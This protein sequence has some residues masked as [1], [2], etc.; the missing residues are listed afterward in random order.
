MIRDLEYF[1]SKALSQSVAKLLL[2]KSALHAL[3]E[4]DR[5]RDISTKAMDIGTIAHDLALRGVNSACV[6]DFDSFRT[7]AAKAAREEALLEG[8]TPIL[9]DKMD[10]VL[11]M[12]TALKSQMGKEFPFVDG[13]AETPIFFE[14]DGVKCKAKPDYLD[15]KNNII[16]DYKT[17]TDANPKAFTRKM[18]QMGY[19]FQDG[20]YSRAL[21]TA[22]NIEKARF[23]FIVQEVEYPFAVSVVELDGF[24]RSLAERKVDLA[25]EKW[26]DAKQNGFNGYGYHIV[27]A[28]QYV[29]ADL[30]QQELEE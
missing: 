19:D 18:F 20:W 30:L 12:I 2:S 1:N 15:D 22:K 13:I 5:T 9:K 21:K 3:A 8:K 23:V 7:N 17:T 6:L 25:I 14:I 27:S 29:E 10:Q 16:Y 24:S 28:P 4:Y 11:E 26:K